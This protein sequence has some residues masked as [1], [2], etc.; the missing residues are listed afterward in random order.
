M[1]KKFLCG[2]LQGK[3]PFAA[4]PFFMKLAGELGTKNLMVQI[5]F[6]ESTVVD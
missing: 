6:L 5:L 1:G 3:N 2:Q 4:Y